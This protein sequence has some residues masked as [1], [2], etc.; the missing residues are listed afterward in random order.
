AQTLASS[1]GT[2][3][4]LTFSPDGKRLLGSG[5]G[6][7]ELWDLTG[8]RPVR[9]FARGQEGEP[10]GFDRGWYGFF[11]IGLSPDGGRLVCHDTLT[12]IKVWEI[13]RDEPP[14]TLAG[15]KSYPTNAVYSPDGRLL[16]TGSDAEVLVWDTSTLKLV[17]KI[18]TAAGWLA[19]DPDSKSILTA[20]HDPAQ[21]L[22]AS[23]VTRW[24]LA[25]FEGRPLPPLTGSTGWPAY[26]LSSDGK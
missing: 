4:G 13:D 3:N 1:V 14:V 25:S 26:E 15:Y 18:D 20:Q 7:M 2:L 5:P 9:T 21:S 23:V 16:A 19:F 11:K 8:Q 22:A 6:G 10:Q 17:K 24:D 12:T